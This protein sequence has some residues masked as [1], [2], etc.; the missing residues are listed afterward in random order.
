MDRAVGIKLLTGKAKFYVGV[1]PCQA[2]VPQ[3]VI[4]AGPI[5]S[6]NE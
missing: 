4:A 3:L 6:G 5:T 1:N 2:D